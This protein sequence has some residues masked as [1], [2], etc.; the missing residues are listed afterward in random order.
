[1]PVN[2]KSKFIKELK[3]LKK[4]RIPFVADEKLE[5]PFKEFT[6]S[7]LRT[8]GIKKEIETKNHKNINDKIKLKIEEIKKQDVLLEKELKALNITKSKLNLKEEVNKIVA[9]VKFKKLH[10]LDV[11]IKLE[12]AEMLSKTIQVL[13]KR[14]NIDNKTLF[15]YLTL[16]ENIDLKSK[17][18]SNG[19][20]FKANIFFN[21]ALKEVEQIILSSKNEKEFLS[22]F[23]EI[24]QAVQ[25]L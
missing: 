8:L 15:T 18:Y 9:E 1:M 22:N 14:F 5:L 10:S 6:I 16:I 24:I 12:S 2:R 3:S 19:K 20:M 17:A 13:I 4:K 7:N 23:R 21:I 25:K 11:I